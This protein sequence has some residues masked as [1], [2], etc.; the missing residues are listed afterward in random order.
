M[1]FICVVFHNLFIIPLQFLV[2]IPTGYAYEVRHN[3]STSHLLK[4]PPDALGESDFKKIFQD[5]IEFCGNPPKD[6]F[7]PL[8]THKNQIDMI[9]SFQNQFCKDQIL[10][11]RIY[12]LGELFFQLKRATAQTRDGQ[13]SFTSIHIAEAHIDRDTYDFRKGIA[14]TVSPC[15]V[16]HSLNVRD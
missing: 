12:P 7:P 13:I 15:F 9:E 5:M 6:D 1:H 2:A 4:G 10:P 16:L 11:Y 3:S 14:C 8:F